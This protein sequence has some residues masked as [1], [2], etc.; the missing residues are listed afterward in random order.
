MRLLKDFSFHSRRNAKSP[1]F[2]DVI[3]QIVFQAERDAWNGSLG[4]GL[5]SLSCRR[6]R[7]LGCG[8]LPQH[9]QKAVP[10]SV[11]QVR[12]LQSLLEII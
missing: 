11:L 7:W 8:S 1:S 2:L 9:I 12:L 5:F 4:L 3:D 10:I 6:L